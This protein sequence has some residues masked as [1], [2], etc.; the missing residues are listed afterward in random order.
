MGLSTRSR[1]RRAIAL[2]LLDLPRPLRAGIEGW[3]VVLIS[4]WIK[5]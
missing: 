5:I 3:V 4:D 2:L 1:R